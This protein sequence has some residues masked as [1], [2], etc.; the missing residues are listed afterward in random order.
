MMCSDR[1]S[2]GRGGSQPALTAYFVRH[3]MCAPRSSSQVMRMLA[4]GRP[5]SGDVAGAAGQVMQR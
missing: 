2:C 1:P 4:S 3:R 5:G